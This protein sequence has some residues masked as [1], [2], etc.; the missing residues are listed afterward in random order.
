MRFEFIFTKQTPPPLLGV[1]NFVNSGL[2]FWESVIFFVVWKAQSS[3]LRLS[4]VS[5]GQ[6]ARRLEWAERYEDSPQYNYL[7]SHTHEDRLL[8]LR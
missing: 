6:E 2:L 7:P 3:L 4:T 8:H 1:F 5:Y